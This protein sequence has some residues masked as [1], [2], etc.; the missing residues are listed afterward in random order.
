MKRIHE[1]TVLGK[2]GFIRITYTDDG[3][4]C[5][6]I[7]DYN[8]FKTFSLLELEYFLNKECF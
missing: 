4:M 1:I 6:T 8:K 3:Y 5:E 7:L 2:T